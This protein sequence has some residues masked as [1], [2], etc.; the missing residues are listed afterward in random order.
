M[1]N[2]L[3][4]RR[5]YNYDT[6]RDDDV[7][8]DYVPPFLRGRNV[9]YRGGNAYDIDRREIEKFP[10]PKDWKRLDLTERCEY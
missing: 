3:Y 6:P 1:I 2:K 10:F 7:L 4:G 9:S 8:S 5:I